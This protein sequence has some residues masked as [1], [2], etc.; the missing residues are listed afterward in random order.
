MPTVVGTPPQGQWPGASLTLPRQAV[1][2]IVNHIVARLLDQL[3]MSAPFAKRWDDHLH[4]ATKIATVATPTPRRRAGPDRREHCPPGRGGCC[5]TCNVSTG[6]V[7]GWG[8][9]VPIVGDNLLKR[10]K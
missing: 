5:N 4:T 2:D 9:L 10:L 1:D 7:T 3:K 8:N 6:D